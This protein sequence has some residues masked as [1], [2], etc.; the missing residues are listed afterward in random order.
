MRRW[1]QLRMTRW[2]LAHHLTTDPAC[3]HW[4]RPREGSRLDSA[5]RGYACVRCSYERRMEQLCGETPAEM[6]NAMSAKAIRRAIR[7]EDDQ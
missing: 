7:Y 4:R 6:L 3:I 5:S 1:I 2:I